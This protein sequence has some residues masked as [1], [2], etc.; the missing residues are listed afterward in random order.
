MCMCMN[1]HAWTE[2]CNRPRPTALAIFQDHRLMLLSTSLPSG[3]KN[4]NANEYI[5]IELHNIRQDV[6]VASVERL[7]WNHYPLIT[8]NGSDLKCSQIYGK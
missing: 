4:L 3:L 8:L 6:V 5:C 7:V 1:D 2:K